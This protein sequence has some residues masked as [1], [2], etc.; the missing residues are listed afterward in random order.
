M[1]PRRR[2]TFVYPHPN[3]VVR[4]SLA[5]NTKDALDDIA[6]EEVAS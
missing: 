6:D 1:S 5:A 4:L 2:E 3:P